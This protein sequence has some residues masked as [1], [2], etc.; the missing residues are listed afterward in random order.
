LTLALLS[1]TICYV[2]VGYGVKDQQPTRVSIEDA[3][4][5]RT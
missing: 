1:G 3:D 4:A 2:A 5:R